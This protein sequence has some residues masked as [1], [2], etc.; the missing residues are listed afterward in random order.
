[1][2]LTD[3]QLD[4]L[5]PSLSISIMQWLKIT[6]LFELA[7]VGAAGAIQLYLI[8]PHIH[9]N[10]IF[11]LC[12]C[13]KLFHALF[14]SSWLI[15]GT[16]LHW[17]DLLSQPSPKLTTYLNVILILQL[18]ALWVCEWVVWRLAFRKSP[19]RAMWK[20]QKKLTVHIDK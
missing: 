9:N 15:I 11:L 12:L 2:Q 6:G 18:V 16:Y 13:F 4:A 17:H 20:S 14:Q 1:M 3:P 19:H 5:S 7:Y 8:C 10:Y